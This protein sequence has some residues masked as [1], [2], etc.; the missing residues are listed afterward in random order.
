MAIR[1]KLW[2]PPKDRTE[3]QLKKKKRK[4]KSNSKNE[5]KK[6]AEDYKRTKRKLYEQL[7]SSNG[8]NHLPGEY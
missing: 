3:K 4:S 1:S 7:A 8:C 6:E 5:L 2:E